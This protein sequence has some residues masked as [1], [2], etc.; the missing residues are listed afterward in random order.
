MVPSWADQLLPQLLMEQFETLPIQ[1]KP[2][3]HMHEGVL[4]RKNHFWR[5]DSCENLDN[6]FLICLFVCLPALRPKSTAM[7]IAGRSVHLTTL[8]SWA[9]LNKQ[10]TSN[11]AHT[12]V[13]NW[14][15]PFMNDSAEG[16]RMTVEI[17]SWSISTK[18]WD[19][20]GIELA[21]PG[22]AV[23]FASVTRHV[24]DCATR[25]GNYFLIWLLYMHW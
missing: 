4:F 12:F 11:R 20:A 14:Q 8:F 5:N 13:C 15:Q 19:R 22:S 7:V 2:I 6:Y 17:I 21:T 1:F 3:E 18:V 25:P 9:S 10:L 16:R 24:T 23:S